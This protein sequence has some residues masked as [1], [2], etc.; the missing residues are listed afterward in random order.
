[1]EVKTDTITFNEETFYKSSYNEVSVLERNKDRYDNGSTLC[2]ADGKD[3][4][5]L[6][7]TQQWKEDVAIFKKTSS[8]AP[9]YE[10]PPTKY[11]N[12]LRGYYVHPDLIHTVIMFCS[13][14][15]RYNV[16]I[17]LNLINER[18]KL[19]NQTLTDNIDDLM[20]EKD[21][22]IAELNQENTGLTQENTGL[23]QEN[24]HL[25]TRAVPNNY[26]YR[27]AY[28][29][30]QDGNDLNGVRTFKVVRR[31]GKDVRSHPIYKHI[32]KDNLYFYYVSYL[33][34][35]MSLNRKI[36]AITEIKIPD[37]KFLAKNNL[38]RIPIEK[39][40][41]FREIIDDVLRED[42]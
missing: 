2:E 10:L 40:G 39:V 30:F 29:I 19:T 27:Y 35:C 26:Q 36:L 5:R 18:N 34:N 3:I 1:M 7:E 24:A 20:K 4:R 33:P 42:H 17:L 15:Y 14:E 28:L 12:E 38:I 23:K 16:R 32:I 22:K 25:K 11:P 37:S 31:I 8:E 41:K 13:P 21:A 9:F 6:F